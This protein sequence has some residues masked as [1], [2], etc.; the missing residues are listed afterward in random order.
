MRGC[1]GRDSCEDGRFKTLRLVKRDIKR[2]RCIY[3]GLLRELSKSQFPP[4]C[5][6][7]ALMEAR[8]A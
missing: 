8:A 5:G 3:G 2:D 6:P 4:Q 7:W 1:G